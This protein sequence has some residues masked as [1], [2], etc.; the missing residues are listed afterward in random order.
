VP[1]PAC[2]G[3]PGRAAPPR[4]VGATGMAAS[5]FGLLSILSSLLLLTQPLLKNMRSNIYIF[6]LKAFWRLNDW[7]I[8][9]FRKEL[10]NLVAVFIF[11]QIGFEINIYIY[12]YIYYQSNQQFGDILFGHSE[13]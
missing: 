12:I 7:Q 3:P 11:D 10:E 2:R 1:D 5:S 6:Y 9:F 4:S 8:K 13:I